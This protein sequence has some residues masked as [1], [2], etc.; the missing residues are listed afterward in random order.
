MNKNTTKCV[1]GIDRGASFTE[2]GVVDAGHFIEKMTLEN[3]DWDKIGEHFRILTTKYNTEHRVFSGSIAGMPS[4]MRERV[5]LISEIEAIGHGGSAFAGFRQCVVVNMGTGT[6]IVHFDD[7][8]VSHLG[9]TGVGGGTIKGLS[10]LICGE[11][12]PVKLETMVRE[13][14]SSKV[15]LTI[16]DLGYKDISFLGGDM[17]ASNFASLKSSRKEDLSAAILTLVGETVGIIASIC[18]RQVSCQKKIVV[19]GKVARSIYIQ[20][21]LEMVGKLYNTSFVFPAD[22]GYAT[23]FGAALKYLADL[24]AI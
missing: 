8:K 24:E 12:D 3:R 13:G 18:A 11:E 16:S 1:I 20:K 21:I 9:G 22:P 5:T 4:F 23:V 10:S 19:T 15:N 6:A 7:G 17:T 2:F 14:Q